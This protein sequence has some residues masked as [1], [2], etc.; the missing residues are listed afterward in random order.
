[1]TKDDLIRRLKALENE[2]AEAAHAKAGAL[3]IEFID[4]IEVSFAYANA[5]T[6]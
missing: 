1:M 3:L 2:D 4:D 6:R 5:T